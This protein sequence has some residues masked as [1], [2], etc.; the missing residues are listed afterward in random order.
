MIDSL[1]AIGAF[2]LAVC[3]LP[4]LFSSFRR[5]YCGTSW[6]FLQIWFWGE[7]T[8]FLYIIFTS[9]DV[10]LLTNYSLNI[11][12]ILCLFYYKTKPPKPEPVIVLENFLILKD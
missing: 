7:V 6:G 1:G 4:E 5:G 8:T 11:I 12:L 3:A 2:L 10:Y 9:M